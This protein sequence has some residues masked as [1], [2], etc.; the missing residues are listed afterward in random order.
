MEYRPGPRDLPSVTFETNFEDGIVTV[1][2]HSGKKIGP[3]LY[4]DSQ[5]V[6]HAVDLVEAGETAVMR[7]SSQ[8]AVRD[9][10]SDSELPPKGFV[11]T[12]QSR[13][14]IAVNSS[15]P[16]N[17]RPLPEQLLSR[18]LNRL[19]NNAFVG[20]SEVDRS[21]FPVVDPQVSLATHVILGRT[22]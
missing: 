5:A 12:V 1:H 8:Q 20:L 19:P 9:L 18:W 4:R 13:W 22:Q 7:V 10:I 21:R 11:P 17:D 2:N 15:T 16:S 3:L 14:S 6:F